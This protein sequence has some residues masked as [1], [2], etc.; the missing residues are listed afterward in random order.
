MIKD[1]DKFREH[2]AGYQH[3]YV[4]IGGVASSLVMDA[5][6]V[7]F[8]ATRDF[9][10]VL[11]VEALD[12]AFAEAFW[13][14]VQQGGYQNQQRS[15][16]EK[17]FYR[18]DHPSD[19]AYPA[20]LELF[21]RNPDNIMLGA[22]SHLTPI[23]IDE[24]VSSLSA[25]LLDANYYEFLHRH[26]I[27][28]GGISVV[29]EACLIPLKASAWL[30]LSRRAEAGEQVDSKNIRKHRNDVFRLFQILAPGLRIELPVSAEADM[31]RFLGAM[32]NE[33]EIDLKQLGLAGLT[34]ADVLASLARIY[35]LP[36]HTGL[37]AAR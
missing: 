37:G 3:H 2:F 36:D 8:R 5:A 9:D 23:P 11:C 18:F 24:V 7:T 6:G 12:K 22:D 30:D 17:Q 28:L 13:T 27:E 15:S 19:P 4:L 34:V 14:F 32:Q 29:T 20:M 21:S 33:K 35:G 25:I 16:G 10:I 31:T 1:I 26:K